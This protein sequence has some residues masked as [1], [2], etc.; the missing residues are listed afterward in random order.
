[1]P[2]TQFLVTS[3]AAQL[4]NLWDGSLFN[5][6]NSVNMIDLPVN[7]QTDYVR[8]CLYTPGTGTGVAGTWSHID[9]TYAAA[10]PVPRA[11]LF[12]WEAPELARPT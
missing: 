11:I 1:M 12:G 6:A 4:N 5:V 10:A 9:Y 2:N 3:T 7:G 8:L